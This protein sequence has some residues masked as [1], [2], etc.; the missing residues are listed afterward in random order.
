VLADKEIQVVHAQLQ[1]RNTLA[2]VKKYIGINGSAKCCYG[3]VDTGPLLAKELYNATEKA[4]RSFEQEQHLTSQQ[5]QKK[6]TSLS[7][8][9]SGSDDAGGSKKPF[10]GGGGGG[11]GAPVK[12]VVTTP[13]AATLQVDSLVNQNEDTK[14]LLTSAKYL[15]SVR[16]SLS[17][18][19]HEDAGVLA[20][21]LINATTSD[22]PVIG[23]DG[24][25][26]PSVLHPDIMDELYLY[27]TEVG[28]ALVSNR[29]CRSLL[30]VT[31]PVVADIGEH[32]H[33]H[34]DV[35]SLQSIVDVTE[36][37]VLERNGEL[38]D[39]DL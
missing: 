33:E 27:A 39:M 13:V 5:A 15:A 17:K 20:E 2:D 8:P 35:P 9:G 1:M 36:N 18:G 21:K 37:A 22:V 25:P 31:M 30:Q 16:I 12:S 10:F 23:P 19:N 26:L 24:N 11:G 4:I 6:S 38:W 14:L 7:S 28:E 29:I 3:L 34:G 32:I